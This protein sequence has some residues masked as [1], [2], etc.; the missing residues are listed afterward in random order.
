[1]SENQTEYWMLMCEERLDDKANLGLLKVMPHPIIQLVIDRTSK[2]LS[3]HGP[4]FWLDRKR[5]LPL[6]LDLGEVSR[7][8]NV[9]Y[10]EKEALEH[11]AEAVEKVGPP[12][13]NHVIVAKAVRLE[14]DSKI[15]N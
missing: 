1:M 12:K 6:E 14:L 10:S 2:I 5:E 4:H 9:Y 11:A 7:S 8:G 15:S 13:P 3:I